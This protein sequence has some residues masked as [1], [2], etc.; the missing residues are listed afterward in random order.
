[1][2][3]AKV[4]T[5]AAVMGAVAGLRSMSAPAIVSQFARSG[6]LPI[7]A[8]SVGFLNRPATIRT[9]AILAAGELI[10]DKLPFMPKRTKAPSVVARGIS[11]GLS[12]AAICLSKRRSVLAGAL[13]G[14]AAAVGAT[15]GAYQLRRRA[16]QKFHLPDPV[17]A[18]V[19]DAIVAG[20]GLLVLSAL[21][22]SASRALSSRELFS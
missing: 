15:Y 12:G 18:I 22:S 20:C 1:M 8:S 16:G 11:G 3:D 2:T 9:T 7:G 13:I 14:A 17:V 4:Y 6:L 21:R 19:E 10:A 5:E